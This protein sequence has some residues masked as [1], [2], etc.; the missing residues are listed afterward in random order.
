[1]QNLIQLFFRYGGVLL[2]LLLEGLSLYLVVQYN[3]PQRKVWV[4]TVNNFTGGLNSFTETASD[5]FWLQQINDSLALE[6]AQLRY[7][8]TNLLELENRRQF[9][10]AVSQLPDSPFV[11]IAARVVNNS[12]TRNNNFITLDKGAADGVRPHMGVI[13]KDGVVGIVR[14][15]SKH[16]S[17]AMSVLHRQIRLT[18]ALDSSAYFGSLVW[19]FYDTQRMMLEDIPKQG[20]PDLGT[21]VVTSGYSYR[22]PRGVPLG[23]VDSVWTEQGEVS[24]NIRV[25][26]FP[27]LNRLE[28]VYIVQNLESEEYLELEQAT[29]NE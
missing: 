5:F 9:D 24:P 15:T 16:Y 26:L 20:T 13:S 29:I 6:N 7:K 28:Y 22:F 14:E 23:R 21:K 8:L 11:F 19:K 18:A 27:D 17:V 10:T 12:V 1:M 2:F 25:R 3:E 4:S